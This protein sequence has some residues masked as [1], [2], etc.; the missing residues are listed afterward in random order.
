MISPLRGWKITITHRLI[1]LAVLLSS[2]ATPFARSQ[3]ADDPRPREPMTALETFERDED[4]DGVPDRWYNLRDA[5]MVPGGIGPGRTCLRFENEKPGRPSR[6]SRAFGLDGRKVEAIVI[7]LWIR[8]EDPHT[9][10]R[11]GEDPGLQINMLGPELRTSRRGTMGPW[12]KGIGTRWTHVAKRVPV[13]PDT[14]DAILSIGQ[15]GAT[16]VLEIDN[17]TLDAIPIGGVSTTNLVRNGDVELGDTEPV[18]WVLE[19]GA[20]RVAPGHDSANGL[21]LTRTGAKAMAGLGISVQPFGELSV[22]IAAKGS[23]LQGATK[24]VVYFLDPDGKP[25][26]GPE[27]GALALKWTGTFDWSARKRTITVPPRASRAVLQ[28]EKGQGAG[29]L[30]VDDVSVTASPDAEAGTWTPDHIEDDTRR[31]APYQAALAIAPGS[32]LDASALLDAPAGSH[33]FVVVRDG[34]LAFEKGGRARFFGAVLLP[35]VAFQDR[36]QAEIL[37][38]RLARSGVNLARLGD[39]DLPLGPGV[40]LFDDSRDDT[41]ALDPVALAR[42]DHLI[43]ALK[44]RGIYVA[45]ELASGRRFRA[46]DNFPG[47][48]KYPPGGGPAAAFDPDIRARAIRAAEAL[49]GHVNPGTKLALRDDPALAWVT[50]A[51]ELSLFD[52]QESPGL[53][54][55]ESAAALKAIAAGSGANGRKFWQATESA[56]WKAEADALRGKGLRVPIAGDSHWR[57]EPEFSAAQAVAGLDLVDDRL[58]WSPPAW[59]DPARRSM[60][61]QPEGGIVAEAARKR[62]PDRPYVVGQFCSYT[63]GAWALPGDGADLLLAA[64]LARAEDW[65]ALVRRGIFLTPQAWGASATGTGGGDDIF[66]IPESLG[67]NPQVFALLPHAASIFL[68]G[69]DEPRSKDKAHPNSKA[70]PHATLPGW[71]PQRGRLTI[72]TPHT[73]AVAGGPGGRSIDTESLSFDTDAPFAI[74]AATALG[75]EPIA[76]AKRLL[77]TAVAHITPT[78][79]RWADENRVE[80]ADPGLPPLLVEPLI[81][82]VV[83][84][85]PGKVRA[86]PLDASGARGE[87]I[88]LGRVADG[89]RLILEG[90]SGV[91]HWELVAE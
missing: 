1:A 37:A 76:Q 81:A 9:G 50:L 68:R 46:G 60:L 61:W 71:D 52:L 4:G 83:W 85:R 54:P 24:A 29:T 91:L 27:S 82:E 3:D 53:L 49:L 66:P 10:D 34:R 7:G 16:G 30:F 45:I 77:V 8:A 88:I 11:L 59:V 70:K 36:D 58:F 87:G 86:F 79:L 25:L 6:I 57:R 55:A 80:V 23:N 31:W 12:L 35:P 90:K 47:A 21:E 84:K 41:E 14:R 78:G 39:L 20:R 89:A 51:G 64:R 28:I 26:P 5:R 62:R 73:Q 75:P 33:G 56:Q 42:L 15:F 19:G 65:D 72:D 44:A 13:P 17:L 74:L 67:G 43:A 2:F 32:G 38:D 63:S 48:G 40:S 18:G 22:N 69:A